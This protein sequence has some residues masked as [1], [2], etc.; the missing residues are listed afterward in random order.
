[1]SMTPSSPESTTPQASQGKLFPYMTVLLGGLATT[2]LTLYGVYLLDVNATDFNI[3][4]WYADYVIPVGA[5]IVGVVAALGYGVVSW[6]SGT[7]I[8]RRLFWVVLF[9][10]VCAYFAAQYIV[11][12][13]LHFPADSQ[14]PVGFLEYYD[15]TARSFAWKQHDGSAGSPLG[16]WGYAFRLLEILGFA[17]GGLAVPALLFAKPYC[18]PCGRY[19]NIKS[20]G[21]LPASV[22]PVKFKKSDTEGE[23]AHQAEQKRAFES[24]QQMIETLQ[25]MG[26]ERRT[27]EF[28][29]AL[30]ALKARRNEISKLP[31]RYRVSLIS[32][33]QCAAGWLSIWEMVGQGKQLKQTEIPITRMPPEFVT[34]LQRK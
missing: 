32:C 5:L 20:L 11:F 33:K 26:T 18:T 16:I 2:A 1:M 9:L 29:N 22:A 3:M 10:Q 4:G 31:V 24:A 19:M 7:K 21:L 14:H 23:L 8:V 27:D 12:Q 34:A 30:D 13:N 15:F 6:W 25:R 17:V 28:K